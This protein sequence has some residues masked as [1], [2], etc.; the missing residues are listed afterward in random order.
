MSEMEEEKKTPQTEENINAAEETTASAEA[1]EK[2][3]SEAVAAE[4]QVPNDEEL[5]AEDAHEDA[6]DADEESGDHHFEE[7]EIPLP[8][9]SD[10][11]VEKLVSEADSLLKQHPV[12]KLKAHF[13]NIRKY[14]LKQLNE[15]RDAKLAA[16]IEGGGNQLDFEYTQAQ[17]EKFRT[18][19]GN[20]R[21]QRK[22]YYD[23]LSAQLNDNL[24][25]KKALIEKLKELVTKDESIGDIFKE[26]N[27]IQQQ[28][29]DTGAVPR[30]E[31]GELWRVYHHHVENFY[32]FIKIN[33][34]LRDLDFKK[35]HEVK[36]RLIKE[37]E[38]LLHMEQMNE[39]FKRLQSLH[40]KWKHVGPVEREHREPLWERFSAITKQMHEKRD[41]HYEALRTKGAELLEEKKALVEKIKAFPIEKVKTH[42]QWQE[43]IKGM[44]AI[45][46][47]FTAIGRINHPDNDVV[48]EEFRTIMRDFNHQ[49]N[50]FYKEQKKEFQDNLD[51]K[52]ALLDRAEQLRDSD[53]WKN[54]TNELKR[55]QAD[56]KRI[57]HVPRSESDKIWKKF[58]AACN[59]FF[60]RLTEHNKS[61]DAAFEG[62]LTEK[63]TLLEQLKA[64]DTKG[65]KK[66]VIADLKEMINR[67]R[68][69]GKVPR[70]AM[71]IDSEF[72]TT[73]DGK[74]KAIDLDRKESQRVR[75]EN[76]MEVLTTDDNDDY[77]LRKERS[78]LYQQKEEAEKEL[79]QLENNM[80]FFSSSN[81]NNPLLKEAQKNIDAHKNTI[82][83]IEEKIKML[84]VKIREVNAAAEAENAA[85]E[86]TSKEEQSEG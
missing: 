36:E 41:A 83:G 85:K 13:D 82:G 29:R 45:R 37:A 48:W 5:E 62:N 71:Q 9:Y 15:E 86:D 74:F 44:D 22:K 69:I 1:E 84:N 39:A 43:A 59:H 52:R 3:T 60:N 47:A 42:Q 53:D 32:E 75:F 50:N 30:A 77:A 4:N 78:K 54:T 68:S 79:N 61:L 6:V 40:K 11:S 19:Y 56:W 16:F 21:A 10:Y 65:D 72:N 33:K 27:D 17:R 67:W 7:D 38:E 57:G 23:N 2:N 25:V 80:G 58:R 18:L 76:R 70:S 12:Q 49:K 31:A 8:D 24:K 34:E 73:L 26:F 81:S 66:Q 46:H 51:K 20:Y 64:Y 14:A 55:I 35:N 63:Q 28:W